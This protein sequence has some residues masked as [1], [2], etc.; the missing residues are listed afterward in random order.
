MEAVIV[1][2]ISKTYST[3]KAL[4][5]DNVSFSVSKG[6][7]FGLIGPD[8][9]GKTSIFR[10]LTTLLLP[11]EGSASVDGFDIVKDFKQIRS[12]VGYMP[13]KFSLYQDLTIEENLNF[14]ATVF[15]TTVEENYHLI[16][17]IYIQIEPFKK[18]RAGKL[19]GGMKQKLALCCALIHKP[20]TLF[21][22]EP[23]TGVDPVSR[24]EFWE[25]LRRL[26]EQG[27]TIIVST[28]Y[29]DEAALCDRVA[30]IQSGKILSIDTP[31]N[32]TKAYPTK[33]YAIKANEMYRLLKSLDNYPDRLNSYA[34]GEYAHATFSNK[35]LDEAHLK[36]FLA[37]QGL[38]G[39]E[40][41]SIPA[42]IEDSF[43][44][45]LN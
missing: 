2:N 9:A 43:I 3:E 39:I 19:S 18:R 14:F 10:M 17:D 21:L 15:G 44:K 40:I 41:K 5:V 34:F 16:K 33:L 36:R 45:L 22:D 24:R 7:L 30:L 31:E 37:D 6:E 38:S 13:G 28:P 1:K 25:M 20:A 26:K 35:T 8:G 32:V 23:T 11:D 12:A 4:A 42:T 27:I 29:M